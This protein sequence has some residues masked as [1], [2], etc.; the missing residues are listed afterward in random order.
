MDA[1]AD[2][3]A[4]Q[5]VEYHLQS[6]RALYD[7]AI[8]G[9]DPLGSGAAEWI[10]PGNQ[11]FYSVS[12]VSRPFYALPQELCVSFPCFAR[13]TEGKVASSFGPPIDDV[14]FEFAAILSLLAREPIALLGLRRLGNRPLTNQYHYIPPP[15]DVARLPLPPAPIHS[16]ELLAIL[17]GIGR[18]TDNETIDAAVAATKLYYA[19]LSLARFDPSGA[20]V[21][22]VSAI[23]CLAGHHYKKQ[24]F[25]FDQT[26]KFESLQRTLHQ[27]STLPGARDLVE[28]CK[29][30]VMKTEHS[31]TQKFRLLISEFLP[32]DFLVVADEMYQMPAVGAPRDEAALTKSLGYAYEARSK[33]VHAGKRFP[34]YIEFGLHQNVPVEVGVATLERLFGTTGGKVIP[35][36]IWFERVAHLVIRKYLL[37]SFAPEIVKE[38]EASAEE[39]AHIQ[40]VIRDLTENVRECLGKLVTATSRF[41]GKAIINPSIPNAEWAD[42]AAT[43]ILLRDADLI[44]GTAD[45]TIEG[46]S[47]L[48]N[49]VVGEAGGEFFSG[50]ASNPFRGNTLLLPKGWENV[51]TGDDSTEE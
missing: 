46:S 8:V 21:S 5:A 2:R 34:S 4:G 27:L 43:V 20:Y 18:S 13:Q 16:P 37:C 40:D 23:E 48:K 1:S 33:Y 7:A 38:R 6:G 31:I 26:R 32:E 14:A 3:R 25:A 39:K 28:Q 30:K 49:R 45:P 51:L 12:V 35:A 22:L 50:S 36:F 42:E 9:P 44:G 24:V 17:E 47:W 10:L 15:Q 29:D 19:G 41:L 11:D